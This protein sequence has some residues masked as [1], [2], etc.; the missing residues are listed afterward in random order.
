LLD[1]NSPLWQ[2]LDVNQKDYLTDSDYL[3]DHLKNH[4]V[5]LNDYS[6]IL[7]GVAKCYEGF[8]KKLL[9]K[10]GYI[11]EEQFFST[12]FRIGKVLN[13]A[14]E[15]RYRNESIYDNLRN[16]TGDNNLGNLLWETWKFNRNRIFHYFPNKIDYLTIEECEKKI[17]NTILTMEHT[18]KT[19]FPTAS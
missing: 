4:P 19:I 6:F 16:E 7:F 17:N 1:K 18:L 10:K 14:L 12:R 8:L 13:P 3:L 5:V 11:N 2:F 9:L 15:D